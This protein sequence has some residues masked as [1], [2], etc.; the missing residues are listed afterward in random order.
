MNPVPLR[1]SLLFLFLFPFLAVADDWPM[2][3]GSPG[4]NHVSKETG[5]VASWPKGDASMI[6]WAAAVGTDVF[7]S[8]VVSGGRIF[9]GTNNGQPRDPS[10][11]AKQDKGVFMAFAEKDGAFL[12][13]AVHDKLPGGDKHDSHNIG[14]CSTGA[15]DGNRVY[16]VSNRAELV[17]ADVEGFHDGENDGPVK[18]EKRAGK[19]DADI[20]WSLDFFKDHG[21]LPHQASASSPVVVGDLVYVLTGHGVE[22]ETGKVPNPD[23][24]SFVAVDK[25]TGK[26]AWK[27]ASPGPRILGGQWASPAYGVVDGVAQVCFPGGDGWVYAFDAL[28]GDLLWK[29]NG[30][31]H[32]KPKPDGSPG[33]PLSFVAAPVYVDHRVLIGIGAD[34]DSGTHP[35]GLRCIDA[36]KRGDLTSTGVLWA[37]LGEEISGT[38]ATATVHD[39]LVYLPDLSGVVHCFEL[40]SGKRAWKHDLLANVWGSAVVADG[41][42]YLRS[43]DGEVVTMALGREAKVLG[44]SVL[45][46]IVHGV[47]VP[48]NGILYVAGKTKLY[49]LAKPK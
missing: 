10:I 18:D 30:K 8:P 36:R 17:C 40:E 48:A 21:V 3:G 22:G 15:V 24:P 1:W 49:A 43:G 45:P 39:G 6:K 9:V 27:D 32:E 41:R 23:A 33:T 12:W 42:L 29:V 16:Y 35:G 11:P 26:I 19:H 37:V 25:A 28:K 38:L 13:Q 4:R 7:S 44:K 2:F 47:V 46:D 5:L 14:I 34:E 20:V 31:A